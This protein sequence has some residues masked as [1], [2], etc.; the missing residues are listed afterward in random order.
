[1]AGGRRERGQGC[2]HVPLRRRGGERR[3]RFCSRKVRRS[4]QNAEELA[5]SAARIRPFVIVVAVMA[6][7]VGLVDVVVCVVVGVIARVVD[8][9]GLGVSVF[10][11]VVA[12]VTLVAVVPGGIVARCAVPRCLVQAEA[13]PNSLPGADEHQ[14]KSSQRGR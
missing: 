3:A 9:L 6:R 5:E 10:A 1:M 2:A 13:D 11:R 12:V 8:L 7:A 14:E 4:G